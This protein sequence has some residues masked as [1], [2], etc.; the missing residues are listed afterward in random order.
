MC[1][2][3]L[4]NSKK[5]YRDVEVMALPSEIIEK[6][7]IDEE[8]RNITENSKTQMNCFCKMKSE[9]RVCPMCGCIYYNTDNEEFMD[10]FID[11]VRSHFPPVEIKNDEFDQFYHEQPP[12]V[13]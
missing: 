5:A 4:E 2:K 11:H 13:S 10:E 1:K 3:Y 6:D 8:V 7:S 12:S 9:Q